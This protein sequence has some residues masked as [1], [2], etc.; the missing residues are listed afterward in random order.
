MAGM[1]E[2]LKGKALAE[3]RELDVQYTVLFPNGARY[4]D[5]DRAYGTVH[6]GSRGES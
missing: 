6:R 1:T 4:E 3:L 5:W 2:I